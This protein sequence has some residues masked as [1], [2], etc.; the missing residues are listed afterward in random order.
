MKTYL[1]VDISGKVLN[2]DYALC[3]AMADDNNIAQIV[4]A[5]HVH[6][7]DKYNGKHLKLVSLIPS[8]KQKSAAKFKRIAK[9]LE[10]FINYTILLVYI[11]IKRP[12][13]IHFQWF[14][15][16]EF[17]PVEISYVRLLK[18]IRPKSKLVYTIHNVFPHSTIQ[19][20]KREKYK[21]R[22]LSI[23]KSIDHYIVHTETTARELEQQFSIEKGRLTVVAHGIFKPNYQLRQN[24][25]L[26][27]EAK[28]T[29][30]FYGF[31]RRNKGAD[32]LVEATNMLPLELKKK[33]RVLIVGRTSDEYLQELQEK[34]GDADVSIRPTFVPDNELYEMIE[35]AD[36]I[37][38]PY[39]EISQSGVLLLALYFRKPLLVSDLPS[40]RETLKGFSA[41]M[42]FETENPKS[43][44]E[45][46]ERMLS[47]KIDIIKELSLIES[48]NKEYSWEKSAT[49][50]LET[51][52][53]IL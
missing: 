13:I 10:S 46:I 50:T 51:Y 14:P 24:S 1:I 12:V 7:K 35:N 40:F 45:L 21:K 32:I 29:I 16:L 9:A 5:A 49:I 8:S 19:T 26:N 47:G 30:I 33:V 41:D 22:F 34:A 17:S 6:E 38:L 53:R 2:Y 25:V 39:R 27:H 43:M 20:A 44:C 42:F 15:F 4:L 11:L 3:N 23:D 48:L 18:W 52:S 36:Y 31:N 28:K 37:A